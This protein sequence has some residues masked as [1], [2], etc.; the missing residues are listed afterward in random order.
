MTKKGA[1]LL[2]QQWLDLAWDVS[3]RLDK[4]RDVPADQVPAERLV[5]R[6]S[7]HRARM[8]MVRAEAPAA[9]WSLTIP[10]RAA[11]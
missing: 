3:G 5:Q 7:Q 6:G 10:R 1:R 4:R 9:W 8:W 11:E 2:G